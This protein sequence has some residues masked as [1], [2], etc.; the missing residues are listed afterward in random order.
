MGLWVAEVASSVTGSETGFEMG[1]LVR[2][3]RC[4][5]DRRE[6]ITGV[7]FLLRFGFEEVS[8][9]F[10]PFKKKQVQAASWGCVR[11]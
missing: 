11:T 4:K 7:F 6:S 10:N 8:D 2:C 3:P 9:A 5:T 1:G